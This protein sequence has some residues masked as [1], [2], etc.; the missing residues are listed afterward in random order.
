MI[1]IA[2]FQVDEVLHQGPRA[3]VARARRARDGE[4]VVLK[5]LPLADPDGRD[6]ARL[7]VAW[8]VGRAFD[9]PQLNRAL[10][11]L[12]VGGLGVLVLEDIGGTSLAHRLAAGALD[13]A[14]AVD[15][16]IELTYALEALHAAGVVHRDVNPGNV[17]VAGDRVQLIDF[18]VASRMPRELAAARP[19]D[20][21]AGTLA[22]LAPEQS[23]RTN[24]PVDRRADLYALGATLYELLT[25]TRPFPTDDPLAL[26]HAHLAVTP[27]PPHERADVPIALSQVV[28]RLLAKSPEDRYQGAAGLR[29]DL[30]RIRTGLLDGRVPTFVLGQRDLSPVL[31]VP[32]RLYG[33]AREQAMLGQAYQRCRGGRPG[34]VL[35]RGAAGVGKSALVADF[36]AVVARDDGSFVAGKHEQVQNVPLAALI[37]AVR[38]LLRDVLAMGPL[39]RPAVQRRLAAAL[40]G[41]A[42]SLV[43]HLPE[44]PLLL[45][46]VAAAS[47]GQAAE[48]QN[49]VRLGFVKLLGAIASAEHPVILALDDLQWAD[50]ASLQ[51]LEAALR[52]DAI[53]GLLVVGAARD[54]GV[55]ADHPLEV[56]IR[57]AREDGAPVLDLRVPPIDAEAVTHLLADTLHTDADEV[58]PLAAAVLTKTGGNPFFVER[59]LGALHDR[60]ALRLD[61][62][63]ARWT[64]DIRAVEGSDVAENVAALLA[65][66]LGQL[67]PETADLLQLAASLGGAFHLDTLHLITGESETV[68]RARMA[69]AVSHGLVGAIAD[70]APRAR[71]W[72]FLHDRLQEAA[73]AMRDGEGRA[74]RHLEIGRALQAKL[75]EAEREAR[76][77]E[78]VG[79]LDRGRSLLTT[80]DERVELARLNLDAG[81][82]AAA[83]TDFTGAVRLF[84]I[85][86]DLLGAD[87]AAA[88][89][90]LWFALCAGIG[91]LGPMA[92]A[93]DLAA[94]V[95]EE[96]ITAAASPAEAFAAQISKL[97]LLSITG[98]HADAVEYA[99]ELVEGLGGPRPRTMEA[100]G[101]EM[102][103]Q[104]A[105]LQAGMGGRTPA[106]L[107]DA[108]AMTDPVA[109]A[110]LFVLASIAGASMAFGHVFPVVI[111]RMVNLSLTHGNGIPSPVAY[112]AWAFILV[113]MG[114][115]QAGMAFARLALDLA[116]RSVAPTIPP[117]VQ[118]VTS[119]YVL[120]WS[121]P[122]A[123]ARAICASAAEGGVRT[124]N[125]TAA[126]WATL[127][128][129]FFDQSRGA[130]LYEVEAE[131]RRVA[132]RCQTE[133]SY[134][135]GA[136]LARV[137]ADTARQ[138][139]G[140]S[141][142]DPE[143]EAA[144][145]H[146][147]SA[148]TIG[149][150][151][152]MVCATIL[153]E[154]DRAIDLATRVEGMLALMGPAPAMGDL[155]FFGALARAARDGGTD[156]LDAALTQVNGWAA[157][158]PAN[159]EGRR[160]LL[161]AERDG[162][163]GDV[164]AAA[165]AYDAAI[166]HA[167]QHNHLHIEAIAN[168]RAGRFYL[169]RGRRT[170]AFAYL[171]EARRAYGRWGA[172]AKVAQLETQ[173]PEV[174]VVPTRGGTMSTTTTTG[175]SVEVEAVLRATQVLAAEDTL[176]RLLTALL[177]LVHQIAG[178][179][180][181]A[182]IMVADGRPRIQAIGEADGIH[183]AP[184]LALE[185]SDQVCAELVGFALSTQ[186]IVVLDDATSAS[187]F[188]STAYVATQ[189][190]RSVLCAPLVARGRPVG[191]IYLE[192]NL[193]TAA[194]TTRHVELVRVLA[195]QAAT[196]V[197]NAV[198]VER[199][200]A[201][202]EDLR[203]NNQ[204]L[205][206]VD[207]VRE[208]LLARTS[209]ELR[210]P[211]NGI[212]GLAEGLMEESGGPAKGALGMIASSG[213]RLAH[214]V[215][216]ILD[217]SALE[218][219]RLSMRPIALDLAE[220]IATV[221][222]LSAP[223]LRGRPVV[224]TTALP[225]R[226][227][228]VWADGDRLE[229]VLLNLVGNAAKFT[230][231]GRIEV[232]ARVEGDR[233]EVW[234]TDT[235][236]GIPDGALDRIFR[237]FEQAEA[238]T[239]RKYG[240]TGL[241]L[242]IARQIV[243]LHGGRIQV[244][245]TA[246]QGST[247]SFSL[248]IATAEQ[249]MA[250][251]AEPRRARA[252]AIDDNDTIVV[253]SEGDGPI[254]LAVDDE[255]VNLQVVAQQ[256]ARRGFRPVTARSGPEALALLDEGL[257]PDLVLLDIMM[258]GMDGYEVCRK[259]RETR[260]AASL[261]V[262][263]L[264]ARNRPA[265]VA[266]GLAVGANDYLTKPF[267][268]VE[269][270]ARMASHMDL[271]R[272]NAAITRFVPAAFLALLGRDTIAQVQLGD[273]V[274]REMTVL[275]ARIVGYPGLTNGMSPEES[276]AFLNG[277]VG[278][279]EPLLIGRGG[280]VD[281]YLGD[282]IQVLFPGA[283]GDAVRAGIAMQAALEP[284]NLQRIQQARLPVRLGIGVHTGPLVLGTVGSPSRMDT[285]AVSDVVHLA[286]RVE[287]LTPRYGA[288]LRITESTRQ[289][290]DGDGPFAMRALDRISTGLTSAPLPIFE[291]FDGAPAA[292]RAARLAT[293]EPF[294]RAVRLFHER[295]VAE[296]LRLFQLCQVM[297]PTDEAVRQYVQ[298]CM[299]IHQQFAGFD[300]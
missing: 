88:D 289:S 69:P 224:L 68:I 133:F 277:L 27:T 299:A 130:P 72:R 6:V 108:P 204:R 227:P 95:L 65:A 172:A 81:R 294:E 231:Q 253:A 142:G 292:V 41:L 220:L 11:R 222:G 137:I 21:I 55:T 215:D 285:T 26:L 270:F 148:I 181:G 71:R 80:L 67:P 76:L 138:L 126:G 57:S 134:V 44:L 93:A 109:S 251:G 20:Q 114:Q 210:T 291:V 5:V 256:L 33:R 162:I 86:R 188:A 254:V 190:P 266:E 196:A 177:R 232:G 163:A 262:I 263:L 230:E 243:E 268:D 281:A 293:N 145:S 288:G 91:D 83:A 47:P 124:G 248:P 52:D 103:A 221:N 16:A 125:F 58:R 165:D 97:N 250:D 242:A 168:E 3:T 247:F 141:P 56:L 84:G 107:L 129:L 19:P 9:L 49:R 259:I 201:Q 94:T 179:G 35:L 22:Y 283:P 252:S 195:S 216:D 147:P 106:D 7:E 171:S 46:D 153:G 30:E 40:A 194:F 239:A 140:S 161:Q 257:R 295:Q 234:V 260:P 166:T 235:G 287:A 116:D 208:D 82:R 10:E 78:V 202:A 28:M 112:G 143:L 23:G 264:T 189:K 173:F 53:T 136:T 219:G 157:L 77:L 15:V 276:F 197:E 182:L 297:D 62:A 61:A 282:A 131:A 39:T 29:A 24:R 96:A 176:E 73:W 154:L 167:A 13:V 160:A 170:L 139:R 123:D 115:P 245:S 186:E 150:V 159:Q 213:R 31:E 233:V 280:F 183:I 60:G 51:I 70:G 87:G 267:A 152:R 211:L 12:E 236:I 59:F 1:E 249:R 212:I 100:W 79:Q 4:P 193:V 290:L 273:A 207:R 269:L 218:H 228:A 286:A 37:A 156:A 2:G 265:D 54:E 98:R 135:D 117:S 119:T 8:E 34:L 217:V 42:P 169:A 92:G 25:G 298:R 200:R 155:V 99:M 261:P 174:R 278:L 178:A 184:N 271:A 75:P 151:N 64:W 258:P 36:A 229:Q 118:H 180:R 187:R 284:L 203:R 104:M 105:A 240:G 274:K 158:C 146:Y 120:H 205:T 127:C 66:T 275:S 128:T 50:A 214:L 149:L 32:G 102:G 14:T 272:V 63:S 241:G 175:G 279:F 191:A 206:E 110:E 38:E 237:P 43:P 45:G 113:A 132:H 198:L 185:G 225:A 18:D 255:P 101:A 144:L 296:A 300:A 223:L 74:R 164:H 90:E 85:G 226:L 192:N 199:L 244:Q 111:L 89:H 238:A 209:H 17:V 246:G 121:M 48:V 122:F